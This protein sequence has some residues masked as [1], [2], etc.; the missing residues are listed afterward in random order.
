M[1][2][3]VVFGSTLSALA[4]TAALL[5]PVPAP[6]AVP[7]AGTPVRAYGGVIV[8]SS[9][10]LERDAYRLAVRRDGRTERP[11]VPA[12]D[13]PVDADVGPG[14]DG[15]PT[16]VYSH[17][18]EVFTLPVNG[19]PVRHVGAGAHP[20]VWR[21]TIVAVDG[22]YLVS[23]DR[24]VATAHGVREL[25]LHRWQLAITSDDLRVRDLRTRRT[26]RVAA[27]G[28]GASFTSPHEVSWYDRG[29]WRLHLLN[30]RRRHARGPAEVSGFA[31]L[32]GGLTVRAE[33]EGED[34]RL[35][36]TPRP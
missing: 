8:F 2:S 19:G 35:R 3:P 17:E 21:D 7:A 18:G 6:D 1:R 11:V 33:P 24:F 13:E 12:S 5:G 27:R 20:T 29:P 23:G 15:S 14:P 30:G 9:F 25:E 28:T 22:P 31:A 32:D 16:L 36:V 10:D 26:R 34:A 4:A